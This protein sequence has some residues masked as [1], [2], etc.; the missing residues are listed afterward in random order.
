MGR[1]LQ[2]SGARPWASTR[3]YEYMMLVPSGVFVI[4]GLMRRRH[5]LVSI[6]FMCKLILANMLILIR[7]WLWYVYVPIMAEHECGK[8]TQARSLIPLPWESSLIVLLG[9]LT[10]YSHW[11]LRP[12]SLSSEMSLRQMT[13]KPVIII[14]YTGNT[15][16]E[17]SGTDH[18]P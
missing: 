12:S 11:D 7:L 2:L 10:E 16:K 15:A 6:W 5:K 17:T 13:A 3:E 18:T 8:H 1:L 14:L 4:V 9:T